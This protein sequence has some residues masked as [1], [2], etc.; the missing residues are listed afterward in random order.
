MTATPSEPWAIRDT[1]YGRW[2]T[3]SIPH[4]AGVAA[5]ALLAVSALVGV[6]FLV[7]SSSLFSRSEPSDQAGIGIRDAPK[8]T[9]IL[10]TGA[11]ITTE[12]SSAKPSASAGRDEGPAE[13]RPKSPKKP[14]PAPRDPVTYSGWAGHGC[15]S[16]SGGGYG[17]YGRYSDGIAGWYT[18][19]SGGY[20]GGSCDGSFAAVP[21]S[22]SPDSDHDNRAIWWWSV[23]QDSEECELEVYVPS[24]SNS[25]D[26]A[27][28]PTTYQVLSGSSAGDGG[29]GGYDGGSG[30]YGG[31]GGGG[32]RA[33]SGYGSYETFRID[34]TANRGSLVDAG[35]YQVEDGRVA[36]LML[37]RGQDWNESGPTYA[38]HAA[39]QMKVTCRS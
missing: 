13:H 25:H 26:V 22:G 27:G 33:Y 4:K 37:D 9:L 5:G 39:A 8:P 3:L 6:G 30:G 38:H 17:E 23:G 32:Y 29:S 35:T 14:A 20:E 10:P 11:P 15:A 2:T 18:V 1:L 19:E 36:V 7:A 16:P 12:P 24:S 31:G 28:N 34:Q 21:M